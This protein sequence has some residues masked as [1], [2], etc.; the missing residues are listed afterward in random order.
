MPE[1]EKTEDISAAATATA[2]ATAVAEPE[3][4]AEPKDAAEE[5]IPVDTPADLAPPIDEKKKLEPIISARNLDFIYNSGKTNEFHAL[6]NISLDIYPEEFI[7]IFGPS[8]C[9]KS[10]LLNV[11]A[12]LETPDSGEITVMGRDLTKMNAHDF[13]MYHRTQIG[14]IYQAYNLITSLTVLEN[15]VLP[16]MFIN[17]SR[18]KRNKWGRAL[19]ERF[20][21]AA[22]ADKIP[23]ELSGGQQ[24]RIGIARSI[25]NNP[26]LILADEPMGNLDSSS[27]KTALG[28]LGELNEKE[29][30]TIIMVTHNPEHLDYADRILYM[31][32]GVITREVVNRDRHSR[33]E[34][35]RPKSAANEI[36]ELMR[37][38][39]G[40]SPEQINILIMPFK[41]KVFA[42][43]FISTRNMEETRVFEEA[44][45]RRLLGTLSEK[46]FF[47]IL[48]RST[49]AGGVGFDSRT[50]GRI[51]RRINRVIRMAYFIYQKGHQ[52]KDQYGSHEKVTFEEK[53]K[54]TTEYLYKTCY[55]SSYKKLSEEQDERVRQAVKD[56]LMNQL[57]KNGFYEVLDRSFREGGVGLNAKSAKAISEEL[58]LILIL[59]FG[60]VGVSQR[61]ASMSHSEREAAKASGDE[62]VPDMVDT[63]G[64][65]NPSSLIDQ[66]EKQLQEKVSQGDD[67]AL[68]AEKPEPEA[69]KAKE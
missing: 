64:E 7:I 53:A 3:L 55:L 27:A 49:L 58:E 32:D 39:Q 33:K 50:A 41:S 4:A 13:A 22:H 59:G 60:V 36:N 35:N 52:R 46:D 17:I 1:A 40:L 66:M 54:R 51:I 43:H 14:M 62:D 6:I 25:V 19:L 37:A 65:E 68:E 45:Q 69:E 24:Q 67:S 30:K 48:D 2:T 44:I 57:D 29:K 18:G 42:H 63:P 26:N 31:K 15:V 5:A 12:G 34:I 28:I 9:G 10:T 20:G 8:G 16:Q 11:M 23:T 21:I 56:R 61:V 38:Y 47:E